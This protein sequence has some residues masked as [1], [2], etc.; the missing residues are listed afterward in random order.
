VLC[1]GGKDSVL[2]LHKTLQYGLKIDYILTIFPED[3]ESMIYHTPNLRYVKKIA[4]SIGINW[5][6]VKANKNEEMETLEKTLLEIDADVLISG[7]VASRYQKQI[8]DK[9]AHKASMTHFAPLWGWKSIDVLNEITINRMDVIIV[10]VAAYG[11]DRGW[12]GVHLT[13]DNIEKLI[14]LSKKYGFDPMGE[15]GDI[16]TF[17]LDSPLFKKRLIPINVKKRW[18]KDYGIME[19]QQLIMEAK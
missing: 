8:F 1:S 10:A 2:A 12:L 18:E 13:R 6:N 15:G 14:H 3:P 16:E 17:V 11:L 4:E 7:G 5:Y 19:I 9:V